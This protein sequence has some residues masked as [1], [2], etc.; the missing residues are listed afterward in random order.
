MSK[1][2]TRVLLAAVVVACAPALAGVS[3]QTRNAA[4][5]FARGSATPWQPAE[6]ASTDATASPPVP[7]GRSTSGL[8]VVDRPFEPAMPIQAAPAIAPDM[9]QP[10]TLPIAVP[11]APPEKWDVQIAD[12]NLFATF[13]RWGRKAGYRVKWDATRHVLI[14]APG[15]IAG[16]F[17]EA[18]EGV[19]GSPGVSQSE[20][21]LEVCFYPNK[22]ARITRRGDQQKECQ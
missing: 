10:A 14:D 21:P 2:G 13:D 15:E 22:V 20:Y 18:V 1:K 8:R 7:E 17:E 11:P 6:H 16:S 12:V 3:E 9:P 19:L 4:R 5:A